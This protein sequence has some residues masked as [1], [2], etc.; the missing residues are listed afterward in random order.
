MPPPGHLPDPG[1]D[2]GSPIFLRLCPQPPPRPTIPPSFRVARNLMSGELTAATPGL[3]HVMVTTISVPVSLR[4]QGTSSRTPS[5]SPQPSLA[6][7]PCPP[8]P[9]PVSPGEL[10]FSGGVLGDGGVRHPCFQSSL[11]VV[12]LQMGRGRTLGTRC[13]SG[14]ADSARAE[15]SAFFLQAAPRSWLLRGSGCV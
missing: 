12:L 7:P 13:H 14:T 11:R 10:R 5:S 6:G 4:L 3:S 9:H 1:I 8:G 15:E 2:P